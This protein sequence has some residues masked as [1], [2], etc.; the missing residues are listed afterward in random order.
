MSTEV[1]FFDLKGLSRYASLSIPTLKRYLRRG[2]PHFKIGRS[3][4]VRRS[5][6]EAWISQ[7]RASGPS[8]NLKAR[9]VLSIWEEAETERRQ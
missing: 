9:R 6:F 5:E 3:V 8:A 4:R 7:F 1:E 2:M